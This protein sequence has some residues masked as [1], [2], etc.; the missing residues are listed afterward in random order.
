MEIAAR[1][2]HS[3][4]LDDGGDYP[5]N[6]SAYGVHILRARSIDYL[7]QHHI[8]V[9]FVAGTS[10]GGLIGGLYAS[11]ESPAAIRQ[12]VSQINWDQVLSGDHWCPGKILAIRRNALMH[13]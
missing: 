4:N 6:P 9:D 11:G 8:P 12:R 3:H 13:M 1:F 5:L 7:E 10:M 2:P